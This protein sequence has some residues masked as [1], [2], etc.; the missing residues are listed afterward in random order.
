MK[1]FLY[2]LSNP[3][4]PGLLKIGYSREIPDARA[5]ELY[6]TG[7]PSPFELEYYCIAEGGEALEATVHD[8]LAEFRYREDR[9]FF[10]VQ[11]PYARAVIEGCC[12]PEVVW[13][14]NPTQNPPLIIRGSCPRCATTFEG[15]VECPECQIKLRSI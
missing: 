13:I 7:V 12:A 8:G 1:I 11:V 5:Q 10:R 9:E 4:Y 14:K 15:K 2:I 6:T 3:A